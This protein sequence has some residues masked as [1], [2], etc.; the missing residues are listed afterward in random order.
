MSKSK[1]TEKTTGSSRALSNGYF[2]ICTR[3]TYSVIKW[4]RI[5]F[6]SCGTYRSEGRKTTVK[7]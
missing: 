5:S 4:S 6:Q 7:I 3:Q 2:V 1:V